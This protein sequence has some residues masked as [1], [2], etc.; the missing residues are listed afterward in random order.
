MHNELSKKEQQVKDI[1]SNH[2]WEIDDLEIWNNI[3]DDVQQK[4][5]RKKPLFW[6]FIGIGAICILILSTVFWYIG[7]SSESTKNQVKPLANSVHHKESATAE[8]QKGSP[9]VNFNNPRH[10]NVRSMDNKTSQNIPQKRGAYSNQKPLQVQSTALEVKPITTSVST[11]AENLKKTILSA[12][13]EAPKTIEKVDKVMPLPLLTTIHVQC[14]APYD[15]LPTMKIQPT[16]ENPYFLLVQ[17]GAN[18]TRW[19]YS[20]P[21][22]DKQNYWGKPGISTSLGLGYRWSPRVYGIASIGYQQIVDYFQQK[23]DE[24]TT[25]DSDQPESVH[26]NEAGDLTASPSFAEQTTLVSRDVLWH[27]YHNQLFV[28][29]SIGYVFTSYNTFDLSG[30]VGLGYNIYSFAQGYYP[31]PTIKNEI[32]K[33]NTREDAYKTTGLSSLA[34]LRASYTINAWSITG[35]LRYRVQHGSILK[36]NYPFNIKNSQFGLEI[37][38]FYSLNGSI[39]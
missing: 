14:N 36:D 38:I 16:K 33:Y 25:T 7:V 31:H 9:Q 6:W 4:D 35:S 18:L 27:N 3:K 37:G 20:Q 34:A 29:A 39:Y 22:N 32:I 1:I 23:Y 17:S 26:I 15:G 8:V 5:R 30:E 19:S 21:F 2:E 11:K 13:K 24:T 28:D 12:T 10:A